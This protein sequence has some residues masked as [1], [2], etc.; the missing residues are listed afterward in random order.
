MGKSFFFQQTFDKFLI[1]SVDWASAGCSISRGRSHPQCN[2]Y[3]MILD[4]VNQEKSSASTGLQDQT[5]GVCDDARACHLVMEAKIVAEKKLSEFCRR[6]RENL[7]LLF[8]RLSSHL[9]F[10][11]TLTR[12]LG[13]IRGA[14]HSHGGHPQ[15]RNLQV[16]LGFLRSFLKFI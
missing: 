12:I 3:V 10:P 14:V 4:S 2:D 1:V 11:L 15:A 8:R 7:Q 16:A 13:A 6:Y 9:Y 5:P